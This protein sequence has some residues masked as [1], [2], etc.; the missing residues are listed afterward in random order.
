MAIITVD[1]AI[2]YQTISGWE[3]AAQAGQQIEAGTANVEYPSTTFPNYDDNLFTAMLDCGINRLRV[4]CRLDDETTDAYVI[5]E[6]RTAVNDN[7]DPDSINLSGFGFE[8]LDRQMAPVV[9]PYKTLLANRGEELFINLCVV[10]F[11]TAGFKAQNTPAEYAE[12]IFVMV[13]RM[14][15]THGV[16]PDAIE[17]VLEADNQSGDWDATKLANNIVAAADRLANNGYPG[18]KFIAPSNTDGTTVTT[19]YTNMK[20]ANASV[21]SKMLELS[22]HAYVTP[23][24]AQRQAIFSAAD[25]DG[26]QTSMLEYIGAD[27]DMLFNDLINGQ[28]SAWEQ[29]TLAYPESGITDTGAQYFEVNTSTWAVTP[30][31]RTKWLRHVFKYVRRD[32][33]RVDAASDTGG[34]TAVAFENS[35]GACVVVVRNTVS[36]TITVEGLPDGTY[37]INYSYGASTQSAPSTYNSSFSNQVVSAGSD[38][39]FTMSS[40]GVATVYNVNFQM[41]LNYFGATAPTIG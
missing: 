6:A 39:V 17:A 33:V 2:T 38:V 1:T 22:Y 36:G 7:A 41:V 11:N 13:D 18:I 19:W 16:V 29:F 4:E 12:F 40:A 35:N 27:L 14:N 32:A 23:S 5:E 25:G 30:Y 24:N 15:D 26:L 28:V 31:A 37:G 20:S 9:L 8:N 3:A 34:F 10:D 21:A